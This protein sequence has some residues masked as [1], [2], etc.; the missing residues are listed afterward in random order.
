MNKATLQVF[1]AALLLAA[2]GSAPAATHYVD[3]NSTNA[4]PPFTNWATAATNIQDAVDAAVAGDEVVVTNG[5][6]HPVV[7]NKPLNV[8]SA[9][10]PQPTTI[11]GGYADTCVFLAN[12]ASLS[13][14]TLI[15]GEGGVYCAS[16]NEVVSSCVISRN[17]AT[18]GGGAYGG[19]LNNCLLSS[20]VAYSC[21]SVGCGG[22]G[23]IYAQ[24][25]GAYYCTLNNCTLT[26]NEANSDY[27]QDGFIAFGGGACNC[28][29]NNCTLTY[30]SA[31][32]SR[33]DTYAGGAYG[34]I[35]NNCIFFRNYAQFAAD[36]DSS[37]WAADPRFVDQAGGNLRLQS[38]SPCIN[39]GNN[40]YAPA[41]PDLDGN[42]RIVG[43]TVDIGAYEYQS[44]SLINFGVVSNQAGFRITGKSN[45]VVIVEASSD[46]ANWSPLVT[47]TLNGHPFSFSDPTPATLP[48]RFYR[49]QAQ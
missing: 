5:T 13:G 32:D 27:I 6:Y 31:I 30:N 35:L 20:N 26:G 49:A 4:T 45:Q 41:G 36:C 39:A 17:F 14:F 37:C 10:G 46:L 48:Q 11:D 44:L 24:G 23:I 16:T 2:A 42:P 40:A 1:A 19:T 29:L 3:V 33:A 9:N 18:A 47:N 22:G 34:C 25:G 28:T 7:V 43:G 8:R 15:N 12:S 38:N 21:G